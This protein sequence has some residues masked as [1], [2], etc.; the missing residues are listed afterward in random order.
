MLKPHFRSKNCMVG[1]QTRLSDT[2]VQKIHENSPVFSQ[3]FPL[4]GSNQ[5]PQDSPHTDFTQSRGWKQADPKVQKEPPKIALSVSHQTLVAWLLGRLYLFESMFSSRVHVVQPT[6]CLI[7]NHHFWDKIP[8]A[9][10]SVPFIPFR[11]PLLL[12]ASR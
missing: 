10:I 5:C 12:D 7:S 4:K 1:N 2:D 6:T 11:P 8:P 9:R 3:N